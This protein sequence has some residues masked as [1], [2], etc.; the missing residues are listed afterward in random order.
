[1]GDGFHLSLIQG[2]GCLHQLLPISRGAAPG[3]PGILWQA[4]RQLF[5]GCLGGPHGVALVVPVKAPQQLPLPADQ[6]QLGGRAAGVYAQIAV[7]RVF[8]QPSPSDPR[9]LVPAA[10]RLVFL[11]VSEQ[12]LHPLQR[13]AQRHASSQRVNQRVQRHGGS[14]RLQRRA[15]GGK[16]VAVLRYDG[17]LF[18]QLQRPDERCPQLRQKMQRSAQKGHVPPDGLSA[19]QSADRLVDHRLKNGRRQIRSGGAV[20]DQRLYIR[21]CKNAAPC[22]DGIDFPVLSR[23][24]VQPLR[25][26]LHQ[27]CHLVDEASCSAG[28]HAVHPLLQPA[29]EVDDLRV[30]PAQ[31][32]RHVRFRRRFPQRGRHRHN[33]LNKGK[34]QRRAD[35]HA[36]APG[37]GRHHSA[38]LTFVPDLCQDFC[39]LFLD[40]CVVADIPA[41]NHAAVLVQHHRLQRR[42]ADID[43]HP[44]AVHSLS[45][46]L[47]S[48]T[49]LIVSATRFAIS[50]GLSLQL[51]FTQARIAP[52]HP[53]T[54]KLYR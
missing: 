45:V 53:N 2:K 41:E 40:L 36:P 13:H 22:G 15:P 20:I 17:G 52:A 47:G 18:R 50:S 21:F 33:L 30:L 19:R 4:F 14:F 24:P 3:D 8:L 1:M 48:F 16:E 26:R 35:A 34:A 11:V 29:G 9:L 42:A 23:F 54:T 25:V 27:G 10:E 38:G 49:L 31:L 51:S 37:H 43:P 32:D 12:R 6:G 44:P 7:P 5:Q 28:A 46:S 39:Q